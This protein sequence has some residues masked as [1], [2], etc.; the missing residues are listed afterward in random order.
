MISFFR[1]TMDLK[2]LLVSFKKGED[3]NEKKMC[4]LK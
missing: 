4:V 3:E 1:Q 2:N